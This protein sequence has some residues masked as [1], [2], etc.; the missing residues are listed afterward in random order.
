M[1][2]L[3]KIVDEINK[4]IKS[5]LTNKKLQS[6]KFFGIAEKYV[7]NTPEEGQPV[8]I[9]PFIFDNNGDGKEVEFD[10]GVNITAYHRIISNQYQDDVQSTYGGVKGKI[11]ISEM[12]MVVSADRKKTKITPLQ[13]EAKFESEFP[14]SVTKEILTGISLTKCMI[15]LIGAVMDPTQVFAGEYTN[16]PFF[17]KPQ[18]AYFSMRYRIQTHFRPGCFDDCCN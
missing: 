14:Q 11:C 13:L 3:E 16:V 1:P 8:P 12:I 7:G 18:Q 15:T 9:Q 17:I 4:T 2:L 5:S 6:N 10:D